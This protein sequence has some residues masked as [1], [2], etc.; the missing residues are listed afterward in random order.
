MKSLKLFVKGVLLY[1]TIFYTLLYMMSIDSIYDNGYFILASLIGI[2]LI[3]A[4]FTFIESKDL[5]TLSFKK[6]HKDSSEHDP[7]M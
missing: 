2:F 1:I 7:E 6:E 4:C 5:D 3:G